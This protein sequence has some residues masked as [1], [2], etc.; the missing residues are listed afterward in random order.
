VLLLLLLLLLVVMVM[1]MLRMEKPNG[2]RG[3]IF[4]KPS[5]D[6]DIKKVQIP[7]VTGPPKLLL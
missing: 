5:V 4:I 1:I 3:G 6:F 7:S 2:R